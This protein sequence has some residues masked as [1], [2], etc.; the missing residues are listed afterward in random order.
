MALARDCLDLRIPKQVL[1][2]VKRSSCVDQ[3]R[4]IRFEILGVRK[5]PNALIKPWQK[6]QQRYATIS[7]QHMTRTPELVGLNH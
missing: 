2:F 1:H 5:H 7:Q 3:K 4:R 6:L